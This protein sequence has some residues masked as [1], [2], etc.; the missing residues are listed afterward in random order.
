MK[1]QNF[2]LLFV[3]ILTTLAFFS[4]KKEEP[5]EE[6]ELQCVPSCEN[7]DGTG[8]NICIDGNCEC[9]TNNWT[10][11]E[12]TVKCTNCSNVV[13]ELFC[14]LYINNNKITDLT[15]ASSSFQ[16]AIFKKLINSSGQVPYKIIS[17]SVT[18]EEGFFNLTNC[19]RFSTTSNIQI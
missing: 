13:S 19:E 10:Y 2:L 4:C 6:P 11:I 12:W 18:L 15:L 8:D 3:I 17:G 16:N 7:I 9:E 5:K 1:N 14:D